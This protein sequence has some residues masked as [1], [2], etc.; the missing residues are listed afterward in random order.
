MKTRLL[1]YP[2]IAAFST[3][4]QTTDEQ[5]GESNELFA[6]GRFGAALPGYLAS[7]KRSPSGSACYKAG[8]CYMNSRSQKSKAAQYFETAIELSP[9]LRTH[10]FVNNNEAS[11]DVYK[12]LGD[13]LHLNFKFDEAINA[14]E[15]YREQIKSSKVPDENLI[16]ETEAR[17][18]VSRFGKELKETLALPSNFK[19]GNISKSG[20]S[21]VGDF[22]FNLS[23]DKTH[24]I[25]TLKIPVDKLQ[26]IEDEKYFEEVPGLP[27]KKDSVTVS[28]KKEKAHVDSIV[29]ICTIGTSVDGQVMLTY[30]DDQGEANVYISRLRMNQWTQP[31]KVPKT[32]NLK[33]WEPDE[34]ISS[35]GKLMYFVSDRPGGYGGKDIYV[36]RRLPNGEWSKAKNPGPPINTEFD[37]EAP[38]PHPDGIT[39]YFSSNRARPTLGYD[40]Y[41]T[42]KT[43]DTWSKP[44]IVGYPVNSS[45]ESVFYQVVPDK[46]QTLT[47]KAGNE[48]GNLKEN[49]ELKEKQK[50]DSL[51]NVQLG[52]EDNYL[53]TIE[54][55]NTPPVTL[56]RGETIGTEGKNQRAI[57]TKITVSE[58]ETGKTSNLFYSKS[59]TGD[60]CFVLPVS[61][62]I[63][64]TYE[65]DGY[66]FAS[67]NYSVTDGKSYFECQEPVLLAL[68]EKGATTTLSNVFFDEDKTE[69]KKSSGDELNR[70]Y[71]L[72]S[73]HPDM[74]ISI[75]TTIYGKEKFFK[76]L[77]KERSKSILNYL[78]ERGIDKKR[79]D[80]SGTR[81]SELVPKDKKKLEPVEKPRMTQVTEMEIT[82]LKKQQT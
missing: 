4:A 39:F 65:S 55:Q 29:N 13:A 52:V 11:D 60:F 3:F 10:G 18:E 20:E 37:D 79:L 28:R 32:S 75:N 12:W 2:L 43:G 71:K 5:L 57:Q 73:D 42:T 35:D 63:A 53:I 17:I 22:S 62:N 56:L 26:R 44:Q 70:V 77:A 21:V 8:I 1:L 47:A 25:Y 82:S 61:N 59:S 16:A 14:Y 19:F 66:L 76:S 41:A 34:F 24:M 54:S 69:V 9:S 80:C 33:G 38:F 45:D 81:R 67:Q 31:V 72:L 7:I 6:H 51:K 78:I 36:C 64:V 27:D 48:P 74:K 46:K 50:K 23:P 49:K 40:I 30:R 58:P 68:L 15:K